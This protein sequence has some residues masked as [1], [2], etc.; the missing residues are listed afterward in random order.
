MVSRLAR[1]TN[2]GARTRQRI[3]DAAASL[4]ESG[5]SADLSLSDIARDAGVSRASLYY[6][7]SDTGEIVGEVVSDELQR[8]IEKFEGACANA[9][10][11]ADALQ[12]FADAYVAMIKENA[13][14]AR[15]VLSTLHERDAARLGLDAYDGFRDRLLN[16]VSAQIERGKLEG[17]V[18]QGV[19]P[20]FFASA[21]VGAV[22]GMTVGVVCEMGPD[23]DYDRLRDS[24]VEFVRFGIAA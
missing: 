12:R 23:Y 8:L 6:Y 14:L 17:S 4:I 1:S 24:F 3:L 21:I 16:L 22:L 10:S 11:A 19:D 15:L 7:F 2:K 13:P 9:V 20:R 5:G 18:R